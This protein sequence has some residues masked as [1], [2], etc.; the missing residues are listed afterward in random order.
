MAIQAVPLPYN[1]DALEPVISADALKIHYEDHYK[2]YVN[3]VNDLIPDTIYEDLSLKDI[4][5]K[6]GKKI[7]WD[8][9]TKIFNNANQAWNHAFFWKCMTP[10]RN[11]IQ[12]HVLKEKINESF[13]SF[14]NFKE[15]FTLKAG[16]LFGSGWCWL[17][18]NKS[19]SLEIL[20]GKNEE[21]PLVSGKIPIF[22]V[23]LWEHAYYV[24]YRSQRREYMD[25]IWELVN[26]SFVEIEMVKAER[27]QQQRKNFK[28][29]TRSLPFYFRQ[30]WLGVN[31][32]FMKPRKTSIRTGTLL[33]S[34]IGAVLFFFVSMLVGLDILPLPGLFT[35]AAHTNFGL[36][37]FVGMTLGVLIGGAC[38][39]LVG[40]GTPM[41]LHIARK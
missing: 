5:L 22:V 31:Q 19:L 16:E 35:T 7:Q 18:L 8:H 23:D 3:K 41:P 36:I 26:W 27:V 33:G 37:M 28:E 14:E 15:Q 17:V 11:M 39:A 38:G 4:V 24:D 12:S 29:N 21:N 10:A 13:G 25:N 1:I 2:G 34:L 6:S 40:I 30:K 32:T 20:L 9:E